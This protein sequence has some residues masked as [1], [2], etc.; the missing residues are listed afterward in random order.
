VQGIGFRYYVLR[1]ARDL[2]VRGTVRNR[3]DGTVEAVLQAHGDTLEVMIERLR[4]GPRVGHVEAVDVEPVEDEM[5][6]AEFEIV[7]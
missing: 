4:H 1:Q 6:Y 2:G 3:P 5:R 7:G